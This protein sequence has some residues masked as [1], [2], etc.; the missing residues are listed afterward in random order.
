MQSQSSGKTTISAVGRNQISSL[1]GIGQTGRGVPFQINGNLRWQ[2]S[3]RRKSYTVKR[4]TKTQSISSGNEARS[5]YIT[6]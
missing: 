5:F 1:D 2:T 3:A 4:I 6:D